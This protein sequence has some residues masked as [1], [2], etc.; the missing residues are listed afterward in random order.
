MNS[1]TEDNLNNNLYEIG[2]FARFIRQVAGIDATHLA[3]LM[4]V[5]LSYLLEFESG[6]IDYVPH[7]TEEF[8][9]NYHI[10]LNDVVKRKGIKL[11][12]LLNRF[13]DEESF[14]DYYYLT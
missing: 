10:V 7:Q 12:D 13:C 4:N 1:T 3:E 8:I 2:A 14:N 5:N 6:E 9:K 11:T